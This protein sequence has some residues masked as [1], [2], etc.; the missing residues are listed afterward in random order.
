M[1][2]RTGWLILTSAIRISICRTQ[3][4]VTKPGWP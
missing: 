2:K 1:I 4:G 3:S